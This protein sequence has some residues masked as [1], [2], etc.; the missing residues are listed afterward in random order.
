MEP[1]LKFEQVEFYSA[2]MRIAAD[3]T[4]R[5]K[6]SAR[7]PGV[8]LVHGLAND[9]EEFGGFSEL[10]RRLARGGYA[11][12]RFDLRG[13]G[14]S[15]SPRG[16]MLV[17]SEWP[18]DLAAAVSYLETRPEVDPER[19][20][21]VGQSMGGGLVAQASGFDERISCVVAWAG[22]ADGLRWL[23]TLWLERRG[24]Q[25]W[26][27]LL[28][29]LAQDRGERTRTGVSGYRPLPSL[30]ALDETETE[31]WLQMQARYPQFLYEAPLESIDSI[32]AFR[33][34]DA[35]D[36]C[37]CPVRFIHGGEDALVPV[38][39]SRVMCERAGS[40]GNL[41]LLPGADHA[42]PIGAYKEQAWRLT[43]AWLDLYLT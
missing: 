37:L 12:L 34:V 33:P 16:R 2:G 25:A 7:S 41:Q 32:L 11:V 17:A 29:L 35:L 10:A 18:V 22:V 13:C 19:I 3:L 23:R 6:A 24:A 5:V 14:R 36:H 43:Q 39:H 4:W 8:V 38:E 30:L 15:G 20:G 26:A 1:E 31:N 9:R 28:A 42:L 40:L 21:L 27:G